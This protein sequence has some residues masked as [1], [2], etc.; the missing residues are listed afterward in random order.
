M[1]HASAGYAECSLHS[2]GAKEYLMETD[3]DQIPNEGENG[4]PEQPDGGTPGQPTPE[5]ERQAPEGE[6]GTTAPLPG[7]PD[8][9][10]S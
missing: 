1:G 7:N 2:G 4:D 10:G 6:G 8:V 3:P 5:Q 9:G